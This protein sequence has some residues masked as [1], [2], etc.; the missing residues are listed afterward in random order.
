MKRLLHT[1]LLAVLILAI[2]V[3]A[4][5]GVRAMLPDY[6][7]ETHTYSM[8]EGQLL[9]MFEQPKELV[10]YPWQELTQTEPLE[11][12][13][14]AW[15]FYEL[16]SAFG[17]EFTSFDVG[18]AELCYSE[19][20]KKG[21]IR[22]VYA[23][24]AQIEETPAEAEDVMVTMT[25]EA[26]LSMAFDGD[27]ETLCWF[28]VET[29]PTEAP[30]QSI[31]D[32]YETLCALAKAPLEKQTPFSDFALH[33]QTACARIGVTGGTDT[34]AALLQAG[35]PACDLYDGR[36]Y[37]RYASKYGSLTLICDPISHIVLGFC[38]ENK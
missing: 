12:S 11:D 37:I 25:G 6:T 5:F 36:A 38:L 17:W 13:D 22:N 9:P 35:D 4:L 15:L 27:K 26:T 23:F 8:A 10:L 31:R 21:G 2:G 7:R 34:V 1:A 29:Q 14:A 19:D 3:S 32:G 33:Y 18:K 24:T 28:F 30:D 20:G 16:S